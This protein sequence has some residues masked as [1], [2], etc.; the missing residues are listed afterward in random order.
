MSNTAGFVWEGNN[1]NQVS[2]VGPNDLVSKLGVIGNHTV[3]NVGGVYGKTIGDGW[4]VSNLRDGQI[5][6]MPMIGNICLGYVG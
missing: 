4:Y 3:G 5:Y 2:L 6:F 1:R